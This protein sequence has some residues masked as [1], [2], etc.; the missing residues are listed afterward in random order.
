MITRLP[1][2]IWLK[3]TP[4]EALLVVIRKVEVGEVKTL[5]ADFSSTVS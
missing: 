4:M 1:F 2:R 5:F 3:T